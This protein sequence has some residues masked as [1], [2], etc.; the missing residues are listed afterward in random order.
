MR[1]IFISCGVALL[2]VMSSGCITAKSGA[3]CSA[4]QGVARNDT[5]V[6]FCV[7]GRWR[8]KLTIGQAAEII[9][10]TWP[11]SAST[12]P[13][14]GSFSIA[15]GAAVPFK[16]VK[17]QTR[18]GQPA[19][20]VPVTLTASD[21]K[22]HFSTGASI[23]TGLTDANGVASLPADVRATALVGDFDLQLSSGEFKNLGTVKISVKSNP[24]AALALVSGN[25]QSIQAG[26]VFQPWVFEVRDSSGNR[27][28]AAAS[29]SITDGGY[30]AITAL[31]PMTISNDAGLVTI[32]APEPQTDANSSGAFVVRIT[33]A[34]PLGTVRNVA[35]FQVSYSVSPGA[36]VDFS[37]AGGDQWTQVGTRFA[38]PV[39]LEVVDAYDNV[40]P[41]PSAT[42]TAVAGPTG[43]SAALTVNSWQF[44]LSAQ[45][46]ANSI[47]GAFTIRGTVAGLGSLDV[48]MTN[49]PAI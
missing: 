9:V 38:A 31:G 32:S 13:G 45:V 36:P 25:G 11:G 40:I 18:K 28:A 4:S 47:E 24:A 34:G 27:T 2:V 26:G 7:K 23:T 42:L 10:G 19:V 1:R 29:I 48:T 15:A 20:G 39:S 3:R 22:A 14:S 46:D 33:E 16:Q 35:S 41:Y 8:P 44:G 49:Q 37:I 6:L 5:H 12:I 43:A 17:V 21:G 30:G